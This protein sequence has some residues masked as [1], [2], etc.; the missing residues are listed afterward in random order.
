MEDVAYW[1]HPLTIRYH[2]LLLDAVASR[3]LYEIYICYRFLAWLKQ[4][5]LSSDG[6]YYC[7]EVAGYWHP[8]TGT[9]ASC[10]LTVWNSAHFLPE[11]M[12]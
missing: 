6:N 12:S 2:I 1:G 8:V 10:L 4:H 9:P 5:F 3:W 11:L 7:L